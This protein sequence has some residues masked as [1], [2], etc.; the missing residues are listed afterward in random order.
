MKRAKFLLIAVPA[1]ALIIVAFQAYSLD[2][3]TTPT[4][5]LF[6][7]PSPGSGGGNYPNPVNPN[8]TFT[9]VLTSTVVSPTCALSNPPCAMSAGTLYYITVN[10][11]NYRL[12]FP[13]SMKLAIN[14][15]HIMVT[16]TY[17]TPSTYHSNQWTP[18]LFFAG[19]VYVMS[20]SYISPYI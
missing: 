9:G 6:S 3:R 12:I 8:V 17:V 19:D 1:I 5:T 7:S 15:V 10:G 4:S 11:L 2:S 18:Q 20:Y 14:G 13:A 16:G